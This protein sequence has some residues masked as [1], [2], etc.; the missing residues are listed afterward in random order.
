[1]NLPAPNNVLNVELPSNTEKDQPNFVDFIEDNKGKLRLVNTDSNLVA[2]GEHH[3]VEFV[4]N[5]MT[6]QPELCNMFGDSLTDNF[7]QARSKLISAA[8]RYGLPKSAIDDHMSAVCI[9]NP[10]HPVKQYLDSGQ[11]DGKER[12]NSVIRCLNAKHEQL[13]LQVLKRW[14]VACVASLY[15]PNFKSK[16]VPV[17]QGEQSFRKTAF[18]ERIAF[19]LPHAFLE[20]AELNPDNKDSVLSCIKAWIVELG[21]LERTNKNSQGSLKAFITKS[22]DTVRPPYARADIKKHRQTNYIATVNGSDFLKDETGSTRFAVIEMK[23][24]ADMSR[25]NKLL[26]W[27]YDGTGSIK[28]VKPEELKQFWLEVKQLYQSGYGWALTDSEVKHAATINDNYQDKGFAYGYIF[29]KYINPSTD[30]IDTTSIHT[31]SCF[32]QNWFTAGQLISEDTKLQAHNSGFIGKA[33]TQLA[34]E[35]YLVTKKGRA[36][37]KNYK[38]AKF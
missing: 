5:Q 2:L 9:E 12:V 22:I 11:W 23:K 18:V 15:E 34:K 38:I 30:F 8:S 32:V 19:V 33:L 7:D 13:A 10:Y 35:G 29:D 17:L 26:G 4:F 6:F 37:S 21:E 25:L 36:N 3:G 14:L 27:H 31:P 16:L 1:M 20:G 28:Q 24:A